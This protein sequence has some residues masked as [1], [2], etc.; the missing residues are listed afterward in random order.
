MRTKKVLA[1]CGLLAGTILVGTTLVA[2]DS[3]VSPQQVIQEMM[4][5]GSLK[6]NDVAPDFYLMERHGVERV[7]LSSFKN[8]KPVALVFGSYT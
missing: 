1:G 7:R 2:Q 5:E 3:Q 6:V 8:E 4:R